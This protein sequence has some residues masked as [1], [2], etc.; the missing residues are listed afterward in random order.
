[1]EIQFASRAEF[2]VSIV[3]YVMVE[4]IL[5]VDRISSDRAEHYHRSGLPHS[6]RDK[7]ADNGITRQGILGSVCLSDEISK[8]RNKKEQ[9]DS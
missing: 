4:A 7:V 2:A 3:H 8:E 1:M 9:R 5:S 6:R